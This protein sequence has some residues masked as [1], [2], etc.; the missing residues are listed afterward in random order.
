MSKTED[1]KIELTN[2]D[3]IMSEKS[4]SKPVPE[5]TPPPTKPQVPPVKPDPLLGDIIQRG[6]KPRDK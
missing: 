3:A 4:D 2:G 1:S 5:P 6:D